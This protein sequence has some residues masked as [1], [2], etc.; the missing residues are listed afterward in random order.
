[1]TAP[2]GAVRKKALDRVERL[3]DELVRAEVARVPLLQI[4]IQT[5]ARFIDW[6]EGGADAEKMIGEA[7]ADPTKA[8]TDVSTPGKPGGY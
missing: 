7:P 1:M 8:P 2:W 4:E 5:I 6:F 3:K